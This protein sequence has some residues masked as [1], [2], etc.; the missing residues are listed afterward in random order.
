ML[1]DFDWSFLNSGL[2]YSARP[3]QGRRTVFTIPKDN[4]F[5]SPIEVWALDNGINF[6]VKKHFMRFSGHN[7]VMCLQ[8]MGL[9]ITIFAQAKDLTS[10]VINNGSNCV[11]FAQ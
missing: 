6:S 9:Y 5:V 3:G 1:D 2:A 10:L 7:S 4:K 8:W 11:L